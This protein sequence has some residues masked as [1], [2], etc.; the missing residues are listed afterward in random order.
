MADTLSISCSP[1]L[2]AGSLDDPFRENPFVLA[3]L[4]KTKGCLG[5]QLLLLDQSLQQT[6]VSF[7]YVSCMLG[8]WDGTHVPPE[9]SKHLKIDNE[10]K[11]CG[12]LT[13]FDAS[14]CSEHPCQLFPSRKPSL[15]QDC[16]QH[17]LRSLPATANPLIFL[18]NTIRISSLGRD[19]V[20]RQGFAS[21]AHGRTKSQVLIINVLQLLYQIVVAR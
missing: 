11:A 5:L 7:G 18:K 4:Q 15:S 14:L 21:N 6:L 20:K 3:E 12:S 2:P 8:A 13:N 9:K 10:I 19:L 1:P 17:L 16:Q